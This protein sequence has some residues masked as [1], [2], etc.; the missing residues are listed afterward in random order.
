V[1]EGSVLIKVYELN[2]FILGRHILFTGFGNLADLALVY[3]FIGNFA[4]V[5]EHVIVGR[6]HSGAVAAPFL[7][8][9]EDEYPL[10][11]DKHADAN[12]DDPAAFLRFELL[13]KFFHRAESSLRASSQ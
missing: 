10:E 4:L 9:G 8:F 1:F 12:A 11:D 7:E 2:G 13:P 5:L 6:L 3:R